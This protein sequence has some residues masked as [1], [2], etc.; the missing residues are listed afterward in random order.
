MNNFERIKTMSIDELALF[1]LHVN[2]AY[3]Q[4]CMVGAVACKHEDIPDCQQCFKEWLESD[5]SEKNA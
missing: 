3:A 5:I 2:S 4:D 1:L